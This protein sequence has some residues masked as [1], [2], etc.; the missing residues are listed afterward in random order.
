MIMQRSTHTTKGRTMTS[1]KSTK[2]NT[3]KK[4]KAI[5]FSAVRVDYAKA[6]D[7]DV[8]IASK[9]LRGKIRNAYGKDTTVTKWL[10]RHN[11]DNKDGNRYGD[12]T[13]AERKAL[14]AL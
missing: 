7:I 4:S 12:V 8:T 9:R 5:P 2:P 3:S 6:K 11:K 13:A 10:D 1:N 14:L